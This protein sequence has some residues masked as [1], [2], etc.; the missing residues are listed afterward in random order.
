M[1]DE[2]SPVVFLVDDEPQLRELAQIFL[3]RQLGSGYELVQAED[4]GQAV[5]L[6]EEFTRGGREV[7]G[8]LMDVRMPVMDGIE[9]TQRILAIEPTARIFIVTAFAEDNLIGQALEAGAV[10]VYN[11][12]IG[13]AVIAERVATLVRQGAPKSRVAAANMRARG[14]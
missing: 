4:G 14:E 13:I 11:K 12:S 2:Q 1:P 5:G 8:V 9:A 6:F 7:S 10:Q 3:Q